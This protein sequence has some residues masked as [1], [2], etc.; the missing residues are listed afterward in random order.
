MIYKVQ[1]HKCVNEGYPE[2]VERDVQT[3][4]QNVCLG[5]WKTT[6]AVI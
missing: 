5:S 6:T 2:L 1:I 4:S 3:V